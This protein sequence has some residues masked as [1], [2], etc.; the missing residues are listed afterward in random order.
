MRY[1]GMAAAE[2]SPDAICAVR[3]SGGLTNKELGY[4]LAVSVLFIMLV[5]LM[6]SRVE[7][8]LAARP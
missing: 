6:A 8:R 2:F 4:A 7:S 1:T 5:T 3:A